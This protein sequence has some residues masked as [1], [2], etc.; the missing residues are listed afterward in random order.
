MPTTA[1]FKIGNNYYI[2]TIRKTL[3]SLDYWKFKYAKKL[4][5]D[6]YVKN[7]CRK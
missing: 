4:K 2:T 7:N 6:H 3:N 5:F 1:K